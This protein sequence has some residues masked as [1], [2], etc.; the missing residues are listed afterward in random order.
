MPKRH[1]V[2][3]PLNLYKKIALTFI[4]LTIILIGIIFYFTLSYAYLTIYPKTQEIKTDFNFIIVEDP[5]L[6]NIEE[7]IFTGKVVNQVI[8]D[9][10][11]FATTGTK[12]VSADAAGSVKI[13]NTLN[14]EQI[15]IPTTRL[16]T[17]DNILFRLKDRVTIP[18]KSTVTAAVYPD[19][20][21]KPLAKAGTKFTIPGLNTTLQKYIYAEAE[22]DFQTGG[23]T[24]QAISQAEIDQAVAEFSEE[25][26]QKVFASE[27]SSK[28]KILS[29]EITEQTL[30]NKVGDTVDSYTLT[31]KIKVIGVIFDAQP[32]TIYAEKL[33]ESLVPNDK[34]LV[35]SNTN[36]LIYEIE[37]YDLDNKLVQIKSAV[38]GV[39]VIGLDSPI[40]DKTK[41]VKLS[42]GEV[43]SYLENFEDIASAEIT[44]FPA[45]VKKMPRFPDHII[46]KIKQ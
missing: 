37:K 23:Q 22:Q 9:Q 4:V 38:N 40:L 11:S 46:I 8:T 43:Q 21:T 10:K 36:Q 34:V 14:Q 30:S 26:A 12:E 32:V 29:K 24:V 39:A 33:I 35:S 20:P 42:A 31:L 1:H 41:L 15:L 5:S 44:F 19:D 2:N 25:A 28:T 3:P 13:V 6:Q 7:G 45:W 16:L 17:A 18:G 27:D